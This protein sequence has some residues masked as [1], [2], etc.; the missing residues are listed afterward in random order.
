M[1]TQRW[2]L[3]LTVTLLTAFIITSCGAPEPTEVPAAPIA[4][5]GV[6]RIKDAFNAYHSKYASGEL[7]LSAP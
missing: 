3:L 4:E 2:I 1:N 6:T 5:D 7:T